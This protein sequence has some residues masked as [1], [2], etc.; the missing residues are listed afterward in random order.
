M[1]TKISNFAISTA[2]DA[3]CALLASG[4][5]RIYDGVRPATPDT[6][7]TTQVEL[8]SL[9]FASVPFRPAFAGVAVAYDLTPDQA[10]VAGT[11]T[12]ARAFRSDG[13]TAILDCDVAAGGSDLNLG[14]ATITVGGLLTQSD[15]YWTFT[16]TIALPKG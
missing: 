4:F 11:P 7:I 14:V 12:W 6:A 15:P 5:L 3:L 8:A 10:T 9:G 2:T 1:A 16:L 13:T